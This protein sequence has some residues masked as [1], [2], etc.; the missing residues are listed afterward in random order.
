MNSLIMHQ[1]IKGDFD[2]TIELLANEGIIFDQSHSLEAD[3]MCFWQVSRGNMTLRLYVDDPKWFKLEV[4][5]NEAYFKQRDEFETAGIVDRS[6]FPSF[7][8]I[9]IGEHR[10]DTIGCCVYVTSK[11][12]SQVFGHFRAEF[13]PTSEASIVC[14]PGSES[15]TWIKR[16]IESF[17]NND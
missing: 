8:Y 14:L 13:K 11:A 4:A 16:L 2:R 15:M 5:T 1:D 6:I 3:G 7:L 17:A 12:P 10:Y 9:G